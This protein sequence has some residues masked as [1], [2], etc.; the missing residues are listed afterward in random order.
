MVPT[1]AM[2]RAYKKKME[3]GRDALAKTGTTHYHAQLEL[4]KKD[5]AFKELVIRGTFYKKKTH[6]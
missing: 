5:C 1:A 4:P 2:S 3:G 6:S